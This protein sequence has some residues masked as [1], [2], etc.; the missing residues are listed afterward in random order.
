MNPLSTILQTRPL[1]VLDGALATELERRGADLHHKLWSAKILRDA[2]ELIQAVHLDY[3]QA[4]ADCAITA[5]YQATVEGFTAEGMSTAEA[6]GLIQKSVQLAVEARDSFWAQPQAVG[7]VRPFIAASVGPYGAFLADGSEYRGEYG[8][9]EQA[10]IE[11]HRPRLVALVEAGAEMIACETIPCL[12]EAR[13]LVK[14]LAEF[15][16]VSAWMSFSC[17]DGEHISN[18][19]RLADC[20][21]FLDTQAQIAAIGVNCTAPTYIVELIQAARSATGKPILIYPNSG[22]IYEAATNTWRGETMCDAFGLQ[23]QQ[24]YAAG[25]RAIGGCCRTTPDHI[26]AVAAWARSLADN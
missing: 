3:F 10:L 1:V 17:R 8:L 16:H 7:R 9:S 13:A 19:E 22:E 6:L 25:A 4:G 23:A 26:R 24:W 14:L 12:I 15:P 2:P 18:G 5:S 11:F 20:A 21:A